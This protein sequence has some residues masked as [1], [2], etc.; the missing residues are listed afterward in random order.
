[1]CNLGESHCLPIQYNLREGRSF[2]LNMQPLVCT[3]SIAVFSLFCPS[4][5]NAMPS[6]VFEHSNILMWP[7]QEKTKYFS[8]C[9]KMTC[10]LHLKKRLSAYFKKMR[11][12]EEHQSSTH[13]CFSILMGD[14]TGNSIRFLASRQITKHAAVK[15]NLLS[16]G[17][18][19]LTHS[20]FL[21]LLVQIK[22]KER[23]KCQRL[24]VH[25][26]SFLL[27]SNICMYYFSMHCFT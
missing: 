14:F 21:T 20:Q 18:E 1:M 25:L 4:P 11:K 15:H 10:Q 7:L 19:L 2:V 8:I 17:G 22:S 26:A 3:F 23:S 24:T 5:H 13:T 12:G 27:H 6:T 16:G 9:N